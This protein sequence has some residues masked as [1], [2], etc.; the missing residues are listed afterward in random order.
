MMADKRS[1][2]NFPEFVESL[3]S[4][5]CDAFRAGPNARIESE[6]DFEQMRQ[7]VLS[8]YDGV[9]V[10]HSFMDS[11]GQVVDCIPVE[12][13]P[14]LKNSDERLLV[15]PP[16]LQLP[17]Q[18]DTRA[19]DSAGQPECPPPQLHPDYR[20]RFGNIM[21]CPSG[22]IPMIRVTLDQISLFRN[23]RDFLHKVPTEDHLPGAPSNYTEALSSTVSSTVGRRHAIGRQIVTN[24]GGSSYL[25]VWKPS[26]LNDQNS[27]SQQWYSSADFRQTV[28][29]GWH[30]C[31]FNY[32][33]NKDPHLFIYWTPDDYNTGGLNLKVP[34]FKQTDNSVMLGGPLY[35][36]SPGGT[37]YEYLMGFFFTAG[38]WWFNFNGTWVGYY[39]ASLFGTGQLKANAERISFGGEAVGSGNLPPMGSGA[40]PGGGF[41]SAAYQ[42]NAIVTPVGGS[43]QPA[44]LV[45]MQTSP[46]CY[47]ISLA[48]NT[49]TTWGT[50]MY[51]GGPAGTT[52]GCPLVP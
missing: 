23:L 20:D 32:F 34:G 1:I 18:I 16:L 35:A 21:W 2:Q 12:Q 26:T 13:Q 3:V 43:A 31:P 19:P 51:F 44:N 15:P 39:P 47:Q 11:S 52:A 48:N 22:T 45:P 25:N 5:R 7:H 38:S 36:S 42:R 41:G 17:P 14:S 33:L 50:F 40:F 8:L 10:Q 49:P 29:C 30:V 46:S 9:E 37:Q 6:D 28:E 4:A 27:I 24:I